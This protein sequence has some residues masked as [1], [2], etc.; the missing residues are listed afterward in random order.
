MKKQ[1]RGS[2]FGLGRRTMVVEQLERRSMMAGNVA[3]NVSGGNLII[4]GD[5]RDNAVLVQQG[6]NP[7]EYVI[8]GFDFAD[9]GEVGFQAGPTTIT[10]SGSA[11]VP[12]LGGTSARLVHHV[13]GNIIINMNKGNDAV[14][15]G[16][17]IDDLIA[18]AESCGF[19][20]GLGSGSGGLSGSVTATAVV[21]DQDELVVPQSLVI[22]MGD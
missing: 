19:G 3:V 5:N 13:T 10:G 17:S 9:S 18:L 11:Q 6:A 15:V 22:N 16:N 4:T 12:D 21:V 14:A 7:G 1:N 2:G 8:T 20:L